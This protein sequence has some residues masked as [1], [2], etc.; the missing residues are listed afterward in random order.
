VLCISSK[1]ISRSINQFNSF[2]FRR[3]STPGEERSALVDIC[4]MI[5]SACDSLFCMFI[6]IYVYLV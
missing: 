4:V 1:S 2:Y 5:T 6:I 3:L